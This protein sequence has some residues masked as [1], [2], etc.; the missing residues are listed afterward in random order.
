MK[1]AGGGR[2]VIAYVID[3]LVLS[4]LNGVVVSVFFT[5]RA[6]GGYD[7]TDMGVLAVVLYVGYCSLFL[8]LWGQTLGKMAM[9]ITVIGTD[10]EDIG[11]GRAAWR[12]FSGM[13]LSIVTFGVGGL[14]D[15]TW[16]LWDRDYQ[17]LHDKLADRWVVRVSYGAQRQDESVDPYGSANPN[18][19]ACN[20]V[21]RCWWGRWRAQDDDHVSVPVGGFVVGV[22]SWGVT[23]ARHDRH[24]VLRVA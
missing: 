8:G 20:Q 17:T 2:R 14:I 7:R 18:V 1:L 9:G 16:L 13:I 11:M 5:E 6:E 12:A 10:F 4:L 24:A 3:V 15:A 21:H 22:G 23:V 19:E